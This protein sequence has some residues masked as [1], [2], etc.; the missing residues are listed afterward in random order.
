MPFYYGMEFI[1]WNNKTQTQKA[2]ERIEQGI[3]DLYTSDN[4]K[5]YLKMLTKL[6]NYSLNNTIL[7][8]SQMPE[9]T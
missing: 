8:L 7:I 6:H 5:Q 1:Y 3:R 4:F 2:F 9:A